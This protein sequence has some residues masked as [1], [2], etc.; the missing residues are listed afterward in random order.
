[1]KLQRKFFS[2]ALAV[3]ALS[4]LRGLGCAK[5]PPPPP[6]AGVQYDIAKGAEI[7][8]VSWYVSQGLLE[9]DVDVKNTSTADLKFEVTV[10]MD[11]DPPV[12]AGVEMGT[13]VNPG[14]TLTYKT[15][16]GTIKTPY[17]KKLYIKVA[18]R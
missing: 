10:T 14:K 6:P 18:P 4:A 1:M 12:T 7:S 3:L 15:Q 17:P 2:V 8:K 13:A 5:E 16:A 11:D 9:V